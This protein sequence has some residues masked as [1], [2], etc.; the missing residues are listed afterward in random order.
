LRNLVNEQTDK[1]ANYRQCKHELII[2]SGALQNKH[3]NNTQD[4][5]YSAVIMTTR[6]LREFIRFIWWM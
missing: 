5:I 4:D 2:K 3:N 1:L 6:S